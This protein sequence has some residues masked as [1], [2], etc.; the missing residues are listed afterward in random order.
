[1]RIALDLQGAQAVN[2]RRGIGRYSRALAQSIVAHASEHEVWLVLNSAFPESAEEIR[3]DFYDSIDPRRIV[4]FETAGKTAAM[5]PQN[6]WRNRAGQLMRTRFLTQLRA[7]VVHTSSL[8]EG[9]ADDAIT[10]ATARAGLLGDAVTLYDLIPLAH[11][12]LYLGDPAV[13]S[14]YDG[15]VAALRQVGLVFA[16]SNYTRQQAIER[17]GLPPHALVNISAAAD[18]QFQPLPGNRPEMWKLV[19]HLGV[20]RRFVLYTGG[21]DPRKNVEGLIEAFAKLPQEVRDG[22]QLVIACEIHA[23]DRSRLEELC[24]HCGLRPDAVAFAGYVSDHDLVALYN[25]C[26][27][28]VFPSLDEGFGLPALEAMCCGA[29]VVAS[30]T[31]SLPEVIGRSDALFDPTRP[32]EIAT[33]M[34]R[35]L[36]DA[37]FCASLRQHAVIQA[38]KFSWSNSAKLAL[39]A[40]E[41]WGSR[42]SANSTSAVPS[43][44][45]H[46]AR[47]RLAYVSPLPPERTGVADYAATLVPALAEHYEIE[48]VADQ[49]EVRMSGAGCDV[50]RSLEWL[51]SNGH[52][53]DRIVYHVGNSMFHRNVFAMM[54]RYP[55]IVILHDFFLSGVA[56]WMDRS[57]F[58]PGYFIPALYG[59]HGYSALV[60][61]AVE[62]RESAVWTYPCNKDVLDDAIGV[63]VHS[64]FAAAL[65]QRWYGS[66]FA[67]RLS[68]V[69]FPKCASEPVD[70]TAARKRLGIDENA[71]VVCS[72]GF[73]G[74]IKLNDRLLRVWASA[75]VSHDSRSRLYFV[76][77]NASGDYGDR[78]ATDIAKLNS[79]A[80]VAITGYVSQEA[81]RDYLAAADVAVQ[82]RSLSRGETSASVI[83]CLAHGLPTIVNANGAN[84]EYPESV[85]WCLDDE[86]ADADL[87]GALDTLHGDE[88]RRRAMGGAGRDYVRSRHDVRSIS[89]K[90]RDAIEAYYA[91]SDR[92]NYRRLIHDLSSIRTATHPDERD[93]AA[94]AR[95]VV[96]N[97]VV[98]GPRRMLVDIS[99]LVKHDLGTGIQRVVREILARL[100]REPPANHRVEPVYCDGARFRMARRFTAR[101]LGVDATGLDDDPLEFERSD[102]FLGL[103]LC[104][105]TIPRMADTLRRAKIAGVEFHFVIYDLLPL[106]RPDTYPAGAESLFVKW[107]ET[108][109]GIASGL[110]CISRSVA[111]ELR[112]YVIGEAV[113]HHDPLRIGHFHLGASRSIGSHSENKAGTLLASKWPRIAA[114]GFTLMVGTVEPRKGHRQTL[115]AFETLWAEGFDMG[116]VIVGKQGWMME[117]FLEQVRRHP[118]RDKRLFWIGR[119]DD[120]L[121]DALYAEATLLLAASE[122]EGFGL[123]VIEA[124]QHGTPILARDLPVF[125]E[126][127]GNH[128]AYFSGVSADELAA[129][130]RRSLRESPEYSR[131]SRQI[132]VLSWEQSCCQLLDAFLHGK[133]DFTIGGDGDESALD[134]REGNGTR[135]EHANAPGAAPGHSAGRQSD[136][137]ASSVEAGDV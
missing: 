103:D 68:L 31:S 67:R 18:P 41:E 39:A 69:P 40:L 104:P 76:G 27:L 135:R 105:E 116:L 13:R 124:A 42:L 70:R 56:D 24:R 89:S 115:A 36:S 91:T 15:C 109:V 33:A 29:P 119:A 82:L 30:G 26:E 94:I 80:S 8:F 19:S 130:L 4:A 62:G 3:S 84:G 48:L 12:D 2:R 74:P 77:E 83:D 17:L 65:A 100:L 72:F 108:V 10:L 1:M 81:Y 117:D 86:F 22:L 11:P 16:I 58:R 9:Y 21:I 112:R 95:S 46:R 133:W 6:A 122:G 53:F 110:V 136:W 123:P 61:E 60:H 120:A 134:D 92:A 66:G 57:R 51:Y 50:V 79:S 129:A 55:G 71:F 102:L 5:H 137:M 73:L 28:F 35:A 118:E 20:A 85:V 43:T 45:L 127:A 131:S 114:R 97:D 101:F 23:T 132:R 125:R 64:A 113:R 7:D 106:L 25:A 111:E 75:R 52:R 93:W 14:W 107:V 128:A 59:S 32:D 37:S 34:Y 87:I 98:A 88:G 121:L 47:P 99:E 54:Q 126:V 49:A 44:T 63:V 90:L 78:L 96:A 38:A